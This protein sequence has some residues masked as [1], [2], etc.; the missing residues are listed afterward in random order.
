MYSTALLRQGHGVVCRKFVD[1][2]EQ[3]FIGKVLQGRHFCPCSDTAWNQSIGE[4]QSSEH[5]FTTTSFALTSAEV[6]I[7]Y[8][9]PANSLFQSE[10]TLPQSIKT[11]LG[12]YHINKLDFLVA[13]FR[14]R[15]GK[16]SY[17]AGLLPVV[18]ETI[19]WRLANRIWNT[20]PCS[21]VIS[22]ITF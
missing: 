12:M 22:S 5:V 10:H 11:R 1:H 15:K 19:T 14:L 7:G 2:V 13:A 8:H 18:F 20:F 4:A 21:S 9:T 16:N 3:Q 17:D 6:T